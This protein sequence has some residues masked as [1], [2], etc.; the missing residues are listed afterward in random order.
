MNT[1]MSTGTRK[2]FLVKARMVSFS[3]SHAEQSV[4]GIRP[5]L[6]RP[7]YRSGRRRGVEM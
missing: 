6:P 7:S 2:D 4:H 1:D 5:G 3:H